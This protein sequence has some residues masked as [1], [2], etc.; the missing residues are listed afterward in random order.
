MLTTPGEVVAG[1]LADAMAA[2]GHQ[3]SKRMV[4]GSRKPDEGSAMARCVE[5]LQLTGTL[6]DLPDP[7]PASEER[8]VEI[9]SSHDVQVAL[10]ELLRARLVK[11]ATHELGHTFGLRHCNDWRCVMSSSHG[12]ERLDVK[13]ASFCTAC[14]KPVYSNGFWARI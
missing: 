11:E 1:A 5:I 3:I 13:G 6:P 9:L 2:V 10:Q 7:F 8:L 4:S 12:V 14:G